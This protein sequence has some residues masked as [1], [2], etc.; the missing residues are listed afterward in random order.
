[1]QKGGGGGRE[2]GGVGGGG[3]F[4]PFQAIECFPTSHAVPTE[5][6]MQEE[7]EEEEE[8]EEKE[9]GGVIKHGSRR[10][11]AWR[12]EAVALE[13]QRVLTAGYN[14]ARR[15]HRTAPD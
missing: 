6:W 7:G 9:E 10:R 12:K 4:T 15:C 3:I 14:E 8:E 2:G 5:R 11:R 1:M 13:Q